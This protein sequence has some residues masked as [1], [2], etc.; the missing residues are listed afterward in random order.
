[1]RVNTVKGDTV[2]LDMYK[3]VHRRKYKE[4][5]ENSYEVKEDTDS[6]KISGLQAEVKYI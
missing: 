5:K 4:R 1:M 6:R 3:Y 2:Y